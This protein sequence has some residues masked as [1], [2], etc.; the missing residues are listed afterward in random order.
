MAHFELVR[1]K[2]PNK[3]TLLIYLCYF[4]ST[5]GMKQC[6]TFCNIKV[7]WGSSRCFCWGREGNELNWTVRCRAHL[8]LSEFYSLVLEPGQ[9][10][11]SFKPHWTC[12]IVEILATQ[13]KLLEQSD[14]YTVIKCTLTFRTTNILG[15]FG[16]VLVQFE[17]V[18]IKILN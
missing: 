2:F 11:N 8:I 10:I 16:C 3:T 13:A 6:T 1:H 14:Y 9:G 5:R 18:K 12:L 7:M 17:L 4:E 15:C